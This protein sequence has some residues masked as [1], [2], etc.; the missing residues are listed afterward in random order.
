MLQT[1]SAD[2][3]ERSHDDFM[4]FGSRSLYEKAGFREVVGRTP[5]RLIMQPPAP[6][7]TRDVAALL[8]PVVS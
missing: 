4:F 8:S 3:L 1:Y 2:K 7:T 6:P 5:T